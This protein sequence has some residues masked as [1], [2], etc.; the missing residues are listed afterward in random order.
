MEEKKLLIKEE[1]ITVSLFNCKQKIYITIFYLILFS[2]ILLNFVYLSIIGLR[3]ESF[4]DSINK[5]K[6][7]D[8]IG[9]TENIVDFVCENEKIC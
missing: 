4:I 6:L 7:L 2:L 8:Y 9:K 5:T 3:L 1:N